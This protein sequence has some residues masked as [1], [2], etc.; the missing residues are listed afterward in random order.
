MNRAISRKTTATGL[1]T[2]VLLF[3]AFLAM[4]LLPAAS[5]TAKAESGPADGNHT[6]EITFVSKDKKDLK[7]IY[8]SGLVLE[9]DFKGVS[10]NKQTNTLTHNNVQLSKE[11][12][13]YSLTIANMGEDFQLEV[14]G[15]NSLDYLSLE[16]IGYDT[17][18]TLTGSGIL[19]IGYLDISN[20]GKKMTVTVGNTVNF[21]IDSQKMGYDK[22]PAIKVSSKSPLTE[23][24]SMIVIK[25]NTED[26]LVYEE[27]PAGSSYAYETTNNK[28]NVTPTQVVK[29][30]PDG[31]WGYYINNKLQTEY[32][33]LAGNSY[34]LWYISDGYADFTKTQL[35]DYQGQTYMVVDGHVDYDF[36][37]FASR[38]KKSW[39]V[40]NSIVQKGYV[41]P[42]VING[43]VHQVD[44]GEVK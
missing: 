4:C 28:I 8:L 38:D 36:N 27:T 20:D 43:V 15:R 13:H 44:K 41:G 34:G 26:Q 16:S 23:M 32:T 9:S 33:G 31:K 18:C 6:A 5:L 17:G 24:E 7:F 37:G 21:N 1:L 39:F 12:L 11:N 25:G 2:A 40:E 35:V 22:L 3:C 30:G 29:R 10:Y 14:I 19:D 42:V